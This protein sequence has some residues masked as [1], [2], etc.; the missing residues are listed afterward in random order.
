MNGAGD[1]GGDVLMMAVIVLYWVLLGNSTR[2]PPRRDNDKSAPTVQQTGETENTSSLT[3]L[4]GIV[5]EF[6]RDF[7]ATAFLTGAQN[8]YEAVLQAY[9]DGD[10][11]TLKRIV[12]PAVLD[13]FERAIAERRE[14]KESLYLTFIGMR[15]AAIVNAV[16]KG[17]TVQIGVRFLA[18]VVTVMRSEDGTIV[19]GDPVQIVEVADAWTFASEIR[20]KNLDWKLVETDNY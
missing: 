2:T 20:P 9:A 19:A 13:V 11:G 17:D 10:T 4:I 3:A 5:R 7:N 12:A 14:R 18:D 8:V 6:D 15:K 16:T 1:M